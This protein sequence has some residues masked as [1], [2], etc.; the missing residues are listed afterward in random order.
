MYIIFLCILLKV[1]IAHFCRSLFTRRS[2][3]SP[4]CQ[5]PE[6]SI[7]LYLLL[8]N[9]HVNHEYANH[10]ASVI[11]RSLFKR[12]CAKIICSFIITR[13]DGLYNHVEICRCALSCARVSQVQQIKHCIIHFFIIVG[14]LYSGR[15]ILAAYL[16][17]TKTLLFLRAL[18][19]SSLPI[20]LVNR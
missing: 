2:K 7:C 1:H 12:S 19:R 11:S 15:A 3:F 5:T 18:S 10:E 20:K 13:R 14:H 6:S 16:C 17:L 9:K 4:I 8:L